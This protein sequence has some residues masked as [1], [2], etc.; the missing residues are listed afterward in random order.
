MSPVV[1]SALT[2]PR[3]RLRRLRSSDGTPFAQI[4]RDP[5]VA[6]MLP[7][8][9]R[10]E[11]GRAFVTRV[12]REQRSGLGYAF[13]IV[14]KKLG[15]PIGQVRLLG[16]DRDDRSAEIGIWIG[17]RWWGD[18]FGPESIRAV[19]AFGFGT[20][21]LH[22]IE[23][24][25]LSGNRRAIGALEQCG[26]RVE[27]RRREAVRRNRAWHDVILLGALSPHRR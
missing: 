14:P 12:S 2:T 24:L 22:R 21:R 8:R 5:F 25:V 11:G 17:R 16:W 18:G 4:L 6:R 27:G 15:R 3:L 10:T 23:A 9:V 1:P 20:M 26:F 19:C 13:A 7:R